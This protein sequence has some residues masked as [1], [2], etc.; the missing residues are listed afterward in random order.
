MPRVEEI[1]REVSTSQATTVILLGDKTIDWFLYL[2]GLPYRRL[3]EFRETIEDY[4][5]LHQ[6]E[7]RSEKLNVL[8]LVHPR[9]AFRLGASSQ[10]WAALHKEWVDSIAPRLL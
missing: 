10:K 9:Q 3:S 8:P 5:R 6:V 2:L 7:I 1:W 4:G